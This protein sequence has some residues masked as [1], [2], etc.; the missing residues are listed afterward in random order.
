MADG[1]ILSPITSEC[2]IL[3]EPVAGVVWLASACHMFEAEPQG[4][5]GPTCR[6]DFTHFVS[7]PVP[8]AAPVYAALRDSVMMDPAAAGAAGLDPTVWVSPASLHLTVVM[9]KLY[10][11]EARLL[12]CEVSADFDIRNHTYP[13]SPLPVAAW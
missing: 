12:A 3:H 2:C 7:I 6:R 1:R 11:G 8:G 4:S 13:G 9:L 5:P 10:S